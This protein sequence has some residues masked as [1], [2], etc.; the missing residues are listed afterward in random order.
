[1]RATVPDTQ[2]FRNRVDAIIAE[3]ELVNDEGI[4][5]HAVAHLLADF[6]RA[7]DVRFEVEGKCPGCKSVMFM[8][9]VLGDDEVVDGKWQQCGFYCPACGWSNAGSRE[10]KPLP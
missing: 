7:R 9:F 8:S 10:V 4:H 1:M 2:L 5:W 6:P 3:C